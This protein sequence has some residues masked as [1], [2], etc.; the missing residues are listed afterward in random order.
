MIELRHIAKSFDGTTVLRDVNAVIRDGEIFAVIGPS[1][2]GKSTL[3]R[4]INL[5]DSPTNG[6]ILLDGTDIHGEHS[7]PLEVR[8]RMAMVFQRP[9][10]FNMSVYENI[11]YGLRL[12]HLPEEEIREK[13]GWALEVIGL[14]G[15]GTRQARTLSGGEMQRVALARALVTAPAVL[16]MDE[17]TANLDPVST[18][19]IE[20]L[21]VRIN[22][23][24]GQTVVI[25]THDM[26][27]GQRL[28]HRIGVLM[29]GVFSQVG[30]PREVFATPKNKH[31]ARF[32]GIE[33]V[34]S[35]EIIATSEGVVTIDTGGGVRVQA[36]AP[37]QVGA[38]VCACIKPEDITL[39]LV[40]GSQVSARNVLNGMVM[41][42]KAYGPLNHLTID[43]GIPLT[44]L[45][46]WK[47]AEDLN[48]RVGTK[49]RLSFKASA[50]HVVE[51]SG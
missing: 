45:I 41:E 27:Q 32:V 18:A 11:A 30:T 24:Q 28:A 50:V 14:S 33:N 23:E 42:M 10:V 44:A 48:I 13:V 49:V 25:S 29:D 39:Y 19:V 15:Y 8:R 51:D 9:A 26:H 34:L 2:S 16:L 4:M 1:G 40:D 5:L 38:R 37:L 46:T 21:V 22:R 17:P 12:R 36:V 6:R 47:S 20:E 31:V 43:C 35:G 7:Q 3:L